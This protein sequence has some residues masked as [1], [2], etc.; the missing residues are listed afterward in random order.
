MET[1]QWRVCGPCDSPRTSGLVPEYQQAGLWDRR[2]I[3]EGT[4]LSSSRA[5]WV[6]SQHGEQHMTHGLFQVT[7]TPSA[8]L[9]FVRAKLYLVSFSHL[10]T[11]LTN[12]KTRHQIP[13]SSMTDQSVQLTFGA[14]QAGD[15]MIFSSWMF[16]P[17]R[18]VPLH[19]TH[20]F[21]PLS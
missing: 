15:G 4:H 20:N 14:V 11:Y 17:E 3:G 8:I 21:N 5:S 19:D 10:G 13:S 1:A 7:P 2:A 18:S 16:K 9:S 12:E 6:V